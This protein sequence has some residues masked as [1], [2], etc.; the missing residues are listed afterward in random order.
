MTGEPINEKR[1]VP[2]RG[3]FVE[4][5]KL[6]KFE[7]LVMSGGE[8]KLAIQSGSVLVNDEPESRVRRKLVAGDRVLFAGVEISVVA[9]A[10]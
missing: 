7:N 1:E 4:L 8:A 9:S 3:E 10:G 5:N 6:L 2:L